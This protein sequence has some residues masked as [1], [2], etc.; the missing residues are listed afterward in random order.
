MGLTCTLMITWEGVFISFEGGFSNGGP[1]GLVWGFILVW[2][3]NIAQVLVMAEMGSM[4]PLAGGQYNWVAVLAPASC[5]KFL[6]YLTGWI[7]VIGWQ[8]VTASAVYLCGSMIQGLVVLNHPSY[9]PERWQATLIFYAVVA[10][11]LF[12][13]TY[14][15]RLLP[16]IEAVVFVIH[17]VGFFAILIPLVYLAPKSSVSDVFD[18][19]I[20]SGNWKTQG[21][22][23]FVGSIQSM[24]AFVGIDAATHLGI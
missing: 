7:T 14:L 11:S 16:Q 6:S 2:L 9:Q 10:V 22:A 20:N 19:F 23:F 17:V 5:S 21:L 1:Q 18:T 12:I 24:F 3:G 4:V 15:A 8:A 13:N